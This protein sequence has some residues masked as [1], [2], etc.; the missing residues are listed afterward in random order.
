VSHGVVISTAPELARLIDA[1]FTG[2]LLGAERRAAM[3]E[4]VLVPHQHPL[5]Q[6]P[7]YGLGVMI[8]PQSRYG[9]IVGHGGGG[10]G[11]SAG[12]LHLPDVHGH[13]ITS[14]ALANRDQDDLGLSLAFQLAMVAA[15]ALED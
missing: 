4:P 9:V 1:L 2:R 14:I 13:R 15:D 11:Y 8:D 3:L 7:A 12:A 6:Q 10:P 5:F